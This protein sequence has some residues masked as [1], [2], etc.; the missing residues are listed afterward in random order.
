M[1]SDFLNLRIEA[2][3]KTFTEPFT[4]RLGGKTRGWDGTP[5]SPW[6]TQGHH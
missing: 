6:Q 3:S 4:A 5:I 2:P 1:V